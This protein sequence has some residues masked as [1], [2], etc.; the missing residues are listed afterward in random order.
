MLL[1]SVELR[2]NDETQSLRLDDIDKMDDGSGY[3][4]VLVVRSRGFGCE[5]QFFFDDRFLPEFIKGL[6]AMH[7]GRP[8]QITLKGTWETD[9]VR[10]EMN[11]KGHLV[12]S[13]SVTEHSDLAQQLHFA[14]RTDPTGLGPLIRDLQAVHQAQR[15]A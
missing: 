9:E 1:G 5:R 4:C 15:G 10:L 6:E 7:A 2:T 14:L 12:V 11:S 8:G 13:G 3:V